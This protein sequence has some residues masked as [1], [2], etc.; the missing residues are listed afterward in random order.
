MYF[1]QM[2]H[3]EAAAVLDVSV[4]SVKL[5]VHRAHQTNRASL[6]LAQG[7]LPV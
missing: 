5:R 4:A 2:S 3:A 1:G 6:E 7:V